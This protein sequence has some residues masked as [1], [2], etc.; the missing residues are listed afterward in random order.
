MLLS[1]RHTFDDMNRVLLYMNLAE[2]I[3][4][5]KDFSIPL[6]L[7]RTK[8]IYNKTAKYSKEL[9]WDNFKLILLKISKEIAKTNLNSDTT[10][11]ASEKKEEVETDQ[12]EAN[13][14]KSLYDFL[15][16]SNPL[17]YRKKMV[18]IKL[19]FNIRDKESRIPKD[20]LSK[21]YKR[22]I[23]LNTST[24]QGINKQEFNK[25]GRDRQILT[26]VHR[27]KRQHSTINE[28][29]FSNNKSN[30]FTWDLL[31]NL[32]YDEMN[33]KNPVADKF[34]PEDFIT[35]DTEDN[36]LMEKLINGS[37][38]VSLPGKVINVY[39]VEKNKNAGNKSIDKS[40]KA[41]IKQNVTSKNSIKSK[42]IVMDLTNYAQ[43]IANQEK[44]RALQVTLKL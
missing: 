1:K 24:A 22:R 9:D 8:E 32:S 6:T 23:Y 43:Q 42:D 3:M 27:N 38:R 31:N 14:L 11:K 34:K 13:Q 16:C 41:S 18:G 26:N 40:G 25:F 37:H 21:K 39:N 28:E 35:E 30:K 5:C 15:E 12:S 33:S 44:K 36:I 29:I 10:N 4:F 2:F 20:D 7:V 19:P 17:H